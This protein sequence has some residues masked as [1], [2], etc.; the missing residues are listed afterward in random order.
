MLSC[1]LVFVFCFSFISPPDIFRTEKLI[2]LWF[3][4]N[5]KLL[6]FLFLSSLLEEGGEEKAGEGKTAATMQM[7]TGTNLLRRQH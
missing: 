6:G 7:R 1:N 5:I 4:S 2:F 3:L